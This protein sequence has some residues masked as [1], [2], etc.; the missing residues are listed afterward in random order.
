MRMQEENM[1][2]GGKQEKTSYVVQEKTT[3]AM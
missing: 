1:N 2:S 3:A